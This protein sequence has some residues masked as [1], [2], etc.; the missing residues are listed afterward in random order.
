MSENVFY[1]V[2]Q[3][4]APRIFFLSLSLSHSETLVYSI[5]AVWDVVFAVSSS[6]SLLVYQND[7]LFL[8]VFGLRRYLDVIDV[9]AG[10]DQVRLKQ[11]L[12]I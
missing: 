6:G 1:F 4:D 9:C 2:E 11:I 3:D 12:L 8:A 7:V 10:G 5:I